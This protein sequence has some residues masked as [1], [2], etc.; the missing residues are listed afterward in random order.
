MLFLNNRMKGTTLDDSS[1]DS[2][3][4]LL[5]TLDDGG[6]GLLGASPMLEGLTT[7]KTSHNAAYQGS[8]IDAITGAESDTSVVGK[9]EDVKDRDTRLAETAGIKALTLDN[10]VA[11]VPLIDDSY[12]RQV[13]V[14]SSNGTVCSY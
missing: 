14:N 3:K 9:V 4:T 8:T 6:A 11:Q 12:W 10:Q 7:M 1:K 5:K 13:E 2:T